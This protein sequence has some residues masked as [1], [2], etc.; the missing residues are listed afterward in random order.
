VNGS[1]ARRYPGAGLGLAITKRVCHLM[2]G[3]I[4]VESNLEEG[5]TFTVQL[6]FK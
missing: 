1:D 2:V 4:W 5:T 6:P 3:D